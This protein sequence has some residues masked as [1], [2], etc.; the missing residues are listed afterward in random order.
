MTEEQKSKNHIHNFRMMTRNQHAIVR[1]CSLATTYLLQMMGS[2]EAWGWKYQFSL[3]GLILRENYERVVHMMC[4]VMIDTS[5]GAVVPGVQANID[6]ERR[7]LLGLIRG[8]Y[9]V[10]SRDMLP[11]IFYHRLEMFANQEQAPM[12]GIQRRV[13]DACIDVYECDCDCQDWIPNNSYQ[14]IYCLHVQFICLRLGFT[15]RDDQ[16]G[17]QSTWHGVRFDNLN[18]QNTGDDGHIHSS[19]MGAGAFIR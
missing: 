15:V 8:N 18:F 10:S 3:K 4:L 17:R 11:P 7:T 16:A 5:E 6:L 19:V 12:V 2:G 1:N 9:L 14:C 13:I